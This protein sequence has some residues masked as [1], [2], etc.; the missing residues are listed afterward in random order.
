MYYFSIPD[1]SKMRLLNFVF[2][3]MMQDHKEWFYDDFKIDVAYGC[4]PKCIWNGGRVEN[5]PE[6]SAQEF[7][8]VI[9]FYKGFGIRY[10]L[11]FTN[12]CLTSDD[13]KDEYG[14]QMAEVLN[15]YGGYVAATFPLMAEYCQ[16]KFNN[17]NLV[18]STS[19]EY[20]KTLD[21]MVAKINVLSKE[22]MVVLPYTFNNSEKLDDFL[23]P[24]NLEIL[25]CD[26]C[27]DNCPK[28]R[29]HQLLISKAIHEKNFDEELNSCIMLKE[30]G[31]SYGTYRNIVN[32]DRL[33]YHFLK[34]I[35]HFK[36]SGRTS[37]E[38]PLAAYAHYFVLPEYRNIFLEECENNIW[39]IQKMKGVISEFAYHP[40]LRYGDAYE[41]VMFLLDGQK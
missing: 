29:E 10:R 41:K 35:S 27:E 24:E 1:S 5:E 14:N 37:M 22:N 31:T 13:L 18:W 25:V 30:G 34:R 33:E 6:Y 15:G 11:N 9:N 8:D 2:L 26:S 32:R 36:I 19:T 17:L 39:E 21:D 7:S 40:L 23:Y 12:Q 16:E 3:Y 4:P 38:S 20:G 28:R